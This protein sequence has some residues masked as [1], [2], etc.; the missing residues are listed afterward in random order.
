MLLVILRKPISQ[1]TSPFDP[2]GLE[3]AQ[4]PLADVAVDHLVDLVVALEEIGQ[5]EDV[6]LRIEARVERIAG[7]ADVDGAQTHAFEHRRIVAELT[8]R[9]N[10]DLDGTAGAFLLPAPRT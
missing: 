8:R 4:Q 5:V 9:M 2:A 7:L 3:G 10:R 1:K 6:Q